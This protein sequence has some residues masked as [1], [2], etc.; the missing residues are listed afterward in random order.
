MILLLAHGTREEVNETCGD[1]DGRTALH[2]ACRKGNV[3][4]LQLLIWVRTWGQG[5]DVPAPGGLHKRGVLR[6]G[7]ERWHHGRRAC[8]CLS[9]A[10][11]RVRESTGNEEGGIPLVWNTTGADLVP[12]MRLPPSRNTF[13]CTWLSAARLLSCPLPHPPLNPIPNPLPKFQHGS[14]QQ[15]PSS[16]PA[17][18]RGRDGVRRPRQHGSGL[19]PPGL[20]PGVHRRAAAVWLPRRAL[21]P[22]GHPKPVQE[23]QQPQQQRREDAHHH[24]R[25][26]RWLSRIRSL[27]SLHPHHGSAL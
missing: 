7:L 18:R 16:P 3:V 14:S 4:L 11:W 2:L 8:F 25:G 10:W 22:H 5:T 6:L 21:R 26:A 19:R 17:V 13:F 15:C 23:E 1:G 20:Q 12:H 9:V 24:L 27:T